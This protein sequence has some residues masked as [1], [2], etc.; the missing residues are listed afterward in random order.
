MK[1]INI[2]FMLEVIASAIAFIIIVLFL[3]FSIIVNKKGR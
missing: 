3:I 2:Y 1:W